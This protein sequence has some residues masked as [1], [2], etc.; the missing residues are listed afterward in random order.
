VLALRGDVGPAVLIRHAHDIQPGKV[1]SSCI[2]YFLCII[3][4]IYY[5]CCFVE[6]LDLPSKARNKA[7]SDIIAFSDR[8]LTIHSSEAPIGEYIP[9]STELFG[10][11]GTKS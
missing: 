11:Q 8:R 3:R 5:I 7:C 4:F 2:I 9:S 6:R 10:A 1:I